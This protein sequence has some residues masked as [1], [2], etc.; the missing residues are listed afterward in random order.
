MTTSKDELFCRLA[1]RQGYL[2]KA[3]AVELIRS[4]REESGVGQEI[5]AF[6]RQ[7]GW[8][9]EAEVKQIE[10]AIRHRAPGH[11]SKTKR[12]VPK[13][14]KAR[15][16]AHT[17]KQ[18]IHHHEARPSKVAVGPAQIT[19]ISIGALVLIGSVIYLIFKF[20]ESG[21]PT[22][23]DAITGK[24]EAVGST[25]AKVEAAKPVEPEVPEAPRKLTAAD[26]EELEKR[27]GTAIF[28][29]RQGSEKSPHAALVKLRED[30]KNMGPELPANLEIR[31]TEQ[32]Q[33]LQILI[34]DRYEELLAEAKSLKES[35]QDQEF[36]YVLEDLAE[37]C[38][39]DLRV[40]AE[41]ALK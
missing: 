13:A 21:A 41:K 22:P 28:S 19:L 2:D 8:L 9:E 18:R 3:Q 20:Q 37:Q 32:E 33:E 26:I 4:Y 23:T 16:H 38:G 7:T 30:L 15:A 10:A 25:K 27:V 17:H 12:R 6:A 11:V 5:S 36:G 31:F 1:M 35:G 14:G 34:Q 29:A 24:T 39:T 40:K